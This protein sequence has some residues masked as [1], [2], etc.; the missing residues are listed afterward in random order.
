M[1]VGLVVNP[2]SFGPE[3]VRDDASRD[4]A[5]RILKA[6]M[7]NA[8][9][10]TE[11]IDTSLAAITD[12]VERLSTRLGQQL[13]ILASEVWKLGPRSR[14]FA[15]AGESS[16]LGSAGARDYVDTLRR[17]ARALRADVVVC[18]AMSEVEGLADLR[19]EGTEYA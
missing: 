16:G 8:V 3:A 18:S 12:N 13:Q 9:S 14:C 4:D 11:S 10:L 17:T 7:R 19:R 5:E 6:C 2:S 1:V 15:A